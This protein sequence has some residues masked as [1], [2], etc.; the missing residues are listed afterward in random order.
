MIEFALLK[1]IWYGVLQVIYD[2]ADVSFLVIY[3]H[4]KLL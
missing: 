1:S 4:F 2:L 3:E